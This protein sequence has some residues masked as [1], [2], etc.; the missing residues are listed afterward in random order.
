M[1]KFFQIDN[2]LMN[3]GIALKFGV[4]TVLIEDTLFITEIVILTSDAGQSG[5]KVSQ[6]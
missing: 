5:H 1:I 3:T 2:F 6:I 4:V